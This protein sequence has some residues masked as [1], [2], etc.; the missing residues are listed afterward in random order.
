MS[1]VQ[2]I[3]FIIYNRI[4]FATSFSTYDTWVPVEH[5]YHGVHNG[6]ETAKGFINEWTVEVDGGDTVAQLVALELGYEFGGP[7]LGFPNTYTFRIYEHMKQRR[8]P[9]E[10]TTTLNKDRR[11]RWAEQSFAKTRVKRYPMPD[12]DEELMRVKRINEKNLS[13]G[14]KN[15]ERE[16]IKRDIL[17]N[18]ELWSY[19][20][21]LQ[22]TRTNQNLPRLDLN[23]LPAY[24]MGYNGR[25]VRVSVLDDGVEYNHTDL[26][27]N[28]DPE[29]SW[30]CNDHDPDP[31]PI[32]KEHNHNSHGTRCA[33]EIAMTANNF[34]CGVGV[35]FGASVGGVRMLDGR[36]T[37]RVEGEAIGYAWDKVDVY[38]ASWGPNDDGRT[39]EGP[40]RLAIEAFKR[41]V[42]KGRNGKGSIYVWANG[43]GGG[44]NDNCNCD[45][46]SSSIYTISIGSASQQGLFPWY[47]E[48]CSST[49][50]TAYSS[51][52]YKDQKIATTDINDT[53]T[54]KHTGTSAA[55]PLAA[56]IIALV[57]H[58][59]PNLT[60][61]DVQHLIVWTSE[62]A[63]L[64]HN[65]GWQINSVGLRFDI[66][67]GFGLLNAGALVKAA[68]NWTTVPDKTSCRIEALPYKDQD[69]RISSKENLDITV[70]VEN[71]T[72][73]YIEHVE[74]IINVKYSRR[75]ALEIYL[76]SPQGTNVQVLSARPRD[77]STAGFV[78]WP[79]TS[80]ATWG[81]NANGI[82]RVIVKDTTNE[83][84][85][86]TFG[87]FNLVIHGTKE[88]PAHMR[89]GPKKYNFGYNNEMQNDFDYFDI[90][91]VLSLVKQYNMANNDLIKNNDP[92]LALDQ[93]EAELLRNHHS[94]S[95][96]SPY[97]E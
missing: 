19:E 83:K 37:D 60:W 17:F 91:N 35:A 78:N 29:I 31:Y 67:F 23:V 87:P 49:L 48:I 97:Y 32:H 53:C 92:A 10:H 88:I 12:S 69:S 33:G 6:F 38:S 54:L 15:G 56:G 86:G 44:H 51:G 7:V 63:P 85:T 41:G 84:N 18:D 62:Y 34:K 42:T 57:L 55:A 21:Y 36:I 13:M 27:E 80:V 82:W 94:K 73:N 8:T 90:N 72:V 59:N 9:T 68:L 64:S 75:G 96:M 46:Y 70:N 2:I 30:D 93:M 16:R 3:I 89:N 61:R 1:L 39:V 47:G 79:L 28:Y 71:C 20:W 77:T 50:A 52:A 65:P 74:L 14:E 25:G 40:G 22:D 26:R 11:I 58:A 81:E 24:R 4:Q 95:F 5:S 66:R 43:N 45:G 76:I